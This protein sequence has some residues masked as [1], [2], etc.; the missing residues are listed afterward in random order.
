MLAGKFIKSDD[1]LA[2]IKAQITIYCDKYKLP[3]IP[4]K[5]GRVGENSSRGQPKASFIIHPPI[6]SVWKGF[7]KWLSQYP[8]NRRVWYVLH[9]IRHELT[10]YEQYL[11]A[12]K[13]VVPI[14]QDTFIEDDAYRIGYQYAD[15]TLKQL[16]PQEINPR[17]LY[18]RFHGNPPRSIRRVNLPI[19]RNGERLIKIG[20]LKFVTYEPEQPSRLAGKLYE[21]EWGDTG[22]IKLPHNPILATDSKGEHFYIIP[23]KSGAK[24]TERGIIG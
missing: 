24:F 23:D 7:S 17:S 3:H 10:H 6:I 12:K 16:A 2:Y 11:S 13:K 5:Y 1:L 19:P 4:I 15:D 9:M 8:E 18:Q 21:H 14:N 20:R 22:R